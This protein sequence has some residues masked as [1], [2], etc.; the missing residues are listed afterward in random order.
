MN[1][2]QY[3]F[4]IIFLSYVELFD[5]HNN[6]SV[7]LLDRKLRYGSRTYQVLGKK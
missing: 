3:V 2:K 5:P 6:A 1:V 7:V 4:L